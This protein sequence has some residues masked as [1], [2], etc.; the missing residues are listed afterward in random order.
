MTDVIGSADMQQ[1]ANTTFTLDRFGNP[2]SALALNGGWTH[3]PSGVLFNTTQFT[4]S[5]WVYPQQVGKNARVIDFGNG[6]SNNIYLA[7]DW[8]NTLRPYFG[9]N[10]GS[11]QL[12]QSH[13][14]Q[15]LTLNRWQFL[16]ATFDGSSLLIYINAILKANSSV[17]FTFLTTLTRTRNYVGKS[18]W[19][20]DGYSSSYLDDL[21]FYNKSL[22]QSQ[23]S[24]LMLSNETNCSV[25]FNTS[26]TTITSSYTSTT[27]ELAITPSTNSKIT[28][29]YERILVTNEQLL[30]IFTQIKVKI[31]YNI[32]FNLCLKNHHK[33]I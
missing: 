9:I 3:V 4:I 28:T 26:T 23:I 13:S 14:S 24:E 30:F 27:S 6:A 8:I 22:S 10:I 7:V 11:T 32:D 19:A 29:F 25:S 31:I 1:G 5:V 18:N 15:S 33:N 12:S 21:R 16:V 17:P 20:V 2:N